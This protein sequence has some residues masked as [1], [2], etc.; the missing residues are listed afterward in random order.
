M[1]KIPSALSDSHFYP[2]LCNY[3]RKPEKNQPPYQYDI[4]YEKD[5][6]HPDCRAG[7][8]CGCAYLLQS[9]NG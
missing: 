5:S 8:V 9:P 7:A 4:D 2:Y 6:F 1:K 3:N